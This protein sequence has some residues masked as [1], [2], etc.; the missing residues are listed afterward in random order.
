MNAAEVIQRIPGV[1]L[2]RDQG[3]GRFVQ[4]DGEPRPNLP[5]LTSTANRFLRPRAMYVMLASM[6][7]RPTR[8]KL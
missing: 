1:T 5:T 6:L 7:F 3:E 2:Q 4:L 8:L